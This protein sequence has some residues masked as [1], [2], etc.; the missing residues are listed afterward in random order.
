[1]RFKIFGLGLLVSVAIPVLAGSIN[2]ENLGVS[3]QT[4]PIAEPD[5]T[6]ELMQKA[7]E[8]V[9]SKEKMIDR[10][11]SYQPADLHDL[12]PATADRTRLVDVTYTLDRDVTDGNGKVIYPKGYTFNPLKYIGLAGGYVI[13]D[14]NDARQVEW[15]K[16]TPYAGNHQVG[17]LLSG[18][19]AFDLVQK[20]KRPVFYLTD[21]IAS[22]LQ[23]T[24]APCLV[25]RRGDRLQVREFY[26]PPKGA[27]R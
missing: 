9:L 1:M 16:S 6:V 11:K 5:I 2:I 24:A 17:L 15:F 10:M 27:D 7:K 19:Y 23:I 21:D 8:K 25:M 3:G 20:L 22:R 4:Y 26:L 13:I 12:P 18:G 14:G